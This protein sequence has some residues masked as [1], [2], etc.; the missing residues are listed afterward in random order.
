[1]ALPTL[2]HRRRL[3]GIAAALVLLPA[4]AGAQAPAAQAA[5]GADA[6]YQKERAACL[7]NTAQQERSACLKEAGAARDEARRSRLGNAEEARALRD[8]ALQRCK[9]VR[10]EDRDGC[11]RMARG[12]GTASGTAAGGGVLKEL[13]TVE[14]AASAASR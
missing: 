2:S 11:E 6:R 5:S 12:E 10:A 3:A 9:S 7:A 13:R 8:N 4:W 1:M 14:P